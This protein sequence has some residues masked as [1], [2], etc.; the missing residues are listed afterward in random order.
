[1][2]SL[3]QASGPPDTKS[4][5]RQSSLHGNW[6]D[7]S[8]WSPCRGRAGPGGTDQSRCCLQAAALTQ[9]KALLLLEESEGGGEEGPV[10]LLPRVG[11]IRSKKK[12]FPPRVLWQKEQS[13][14]MSLGKGCTF[15]ET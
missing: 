10:G 6:Q 14:R 13:L 11:H 2:G 9:A 15:T 1:M 3:L 7:C 4:R 12:Y 5:S 8:E